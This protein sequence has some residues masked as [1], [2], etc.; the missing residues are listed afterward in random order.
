M[1]G[2][3]SPTW[4]IYHPLRLFFLVDWPINDHWIQDLNYRSSTGCILL[5]SWII[6]F[7]VGSCVN[8][9]WSQHLIRMSALNHRSHKIYF[10]KPTFLP[11]PIL[12]WTIAWRLTST[13]AILRS[14]QRFQLR[15]NA[16][17]PSG[18]WDFCNRPHGNHP[19]LVNRGNSSLRFLPCRYKVNG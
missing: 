10:S 4:S 16:R 2:I 5:P 1:F 13:I 19:I 18:I 12:I 8:G 3:L 6:T 14:L 9:N 15:L 7:P 11:H 17:N